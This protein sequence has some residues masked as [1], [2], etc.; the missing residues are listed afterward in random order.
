MHYY[1]HKETVFNQVY[2]EKGWANPTKMFVNGTI[3]PKLMIKWTKEESKEF[4]WNGKRKYAINRVVKTYEYRSIQAYRKSKK[5]WDVFEV[6]QECTYTLKRSRLIYHIRDYELLQ[7]E[8]DELIDSLYARLCNLVNTSYNL[9]R[10]IDKE[11]Q[12]EKVLS[13]LTSHFRR[14]LM[15]LKCSTNLRI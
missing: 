8:E 9:V 13:S 1:G 14:S 3:I 4:D 7:L 5:S 12:D 11:K 10:P 15:L 2:V 6:I